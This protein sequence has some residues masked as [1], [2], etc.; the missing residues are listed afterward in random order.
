M[1]T[2]MIVIFVI[3]RD[4]ETAENVNFF[5]ERKFFRVVHSV[6]HLCR[7][8]MAAKVLQLKKNYDCQGVPITKETMTAKVLQLKRNYDCKG[9]FGYLLLQCRSARLEDT[10]CSDGQDSGE[11]QSDRNLNYRL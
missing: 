5:L 1:G 9:A 11:E 8:T 7:K 10:G 2:A 6:T 3:S 4:L